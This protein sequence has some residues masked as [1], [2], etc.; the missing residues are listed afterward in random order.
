MFER[1]TLF[2]GTTSVTSKVALMAGSS[3]HGNDLRASEA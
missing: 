3:Q 1:A 2:L